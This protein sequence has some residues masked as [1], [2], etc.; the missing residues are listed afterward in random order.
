MKVKDLK[1]TL[2]LLVPVLFCFVA[3][4]ASEDVEDSRETPQSYAAETSSNNFY[5]AQFNAPYRPNKTKR[6]FF[7]K[8]CSLGSSESYYSK[9][10]YF[11]D[12]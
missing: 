1:S 2:W 10:S 12:R 11:C 4:C 5:G 8:D 3:G 9:T 6:P 7:Y